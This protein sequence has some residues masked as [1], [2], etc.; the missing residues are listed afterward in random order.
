MSSNTGGK[1]R[2]TTPGGSKASF[3]KRAA[4]LLVLSGLALG[5]AKAAEYKV[6]LE[7]AYPP[8]ASAQIYQP[9]LDYL[10]AETG[11]RFVAVTP[12]NYNF[13]WRDLRQNEPTDFAFEEAHF[14]DYRAQR[15]GFRPLA[16]LAEPTVYSLVALP[17]TAEQGLDSLIGKPLISMT[18]P[19]LGYAL[20]SEMFSN[21]IAQ[22]DIRSEAASWRDGVEMIFGGEADAAM[23]PRFIAVLYPNL[24]VMQTTREF[25]GAAFSA[26]P[27]VPQEV[28]DAVRSA[29]LKLHENPSA[30]E[31]LVEIGSTRFQPASVDDY[32][33]SRDVLKGFFGYQ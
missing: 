11:H 4:S 21:P 10:T 25:P 15:F 9:L 14:T 2:V 5:T 20:V 13:H 31:V 33:G 28:V 17:Q 3:L 24:Q 22:P 29:L 23:V 26:S 7:P 27:N 19:S 16:R 1:H 32:R 30:Y 12:R 18:S 6:T 8:E